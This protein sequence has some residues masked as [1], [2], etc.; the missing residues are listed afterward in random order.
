MKKKNP[1]DLLT[2]SILVQRETSIWTERRTEQQWK[3]K[4]ELREVPPK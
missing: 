2:T 4:N 3:D 1:K